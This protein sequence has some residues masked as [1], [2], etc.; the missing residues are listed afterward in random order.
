MN[1][2]F[3]NKTKSPQELVK[4]VKDAI[5]RLTPSD[6]KPAEDIS[7]SLA[8]MKIILYGDGDNDPSPEL[9]AQLSQEIYSNDIL[10]LLVKHMAL[11]EFEAKKDVAQIFNNL[12][13]RQ[14]GTRYPTVDYLARSE[15]ILFSLQLGYENQEIAL[16]C[17]MIL[18]ECA[19]HE[20]LARILLLSP[21]FYQY[22]DYV[23]VGSFDVASDAFATFRELLTR[24]KAQVAVFLQEN[25][26]TFFERYTVLLNSENYVT[27]RQSIKL[28]GEILLDRA[29]FN[30]MTKYISNPDNLKLMMNLLRDKSRNIQ[31][32]AFHVFKVFVAN[33]NKNRPVSDILRK[34]RE[35]LITFLGN[36]HNDRTDDDQFNSEK[37]FLIK[38]IQ[39][40]A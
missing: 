38:Q 21:K 25:Y 6:K 11:L 2:F 29:N 16:S 34:N 33:P 40:M 15:D 23:E 26:D 8:A 20:P 13:R 14:V 30:V 3:K 1:I 4:I 31:F 12:L 39:D 7:K 9:I 28:L 19:R 10:G 36:F 18:R 24:H 22:F 37:A 35:K 17:G 27:K 32:E 5:N